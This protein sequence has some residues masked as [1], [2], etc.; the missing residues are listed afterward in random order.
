MMER[1]HPEFMK[2]DMEHMEKSIETLPVN[3]GKGLE[4]WTNT[5]SREI[6]PLNPTEAPLVIAALRELADTI[7]KVVPESG[8][9]ADSI[10]ELV[11]GKRAMVVKV[12]R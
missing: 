10:R 3:I 2:L 8:K 7:A 11:T 9:T 1:V 5:M 4:Y 6:G 12:P